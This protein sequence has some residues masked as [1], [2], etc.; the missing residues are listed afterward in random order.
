MRFIIRNSMCLMQINIKEHY[1]TW[2]NKIINLKYKEKIFPRYID[3]VKTLSL[4][5]NSNK[6]Y[7]LLKKYENNNKSNKV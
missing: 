7:N 1:V 2:C 5:T 6:I 3:Y 4:E